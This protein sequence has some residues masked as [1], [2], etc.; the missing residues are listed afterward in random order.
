MGL[1]QNTDQAYREED[2][3]VDWCK[4]NNLALN[5][6]N[7]IIVD[8]W[9][10]QPSHRPLSIKN[11]AVEIVSSTRF[12][13]TQTHLLGLSTSGPLKRGLSSTFTLCAG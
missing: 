11:T 5:V 9:K 12:L 13:E 10:H 8:F 2:S 4:I 7:E 3:L 1:I 6:T